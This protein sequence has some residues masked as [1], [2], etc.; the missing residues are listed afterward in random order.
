MGCG[1][2]FVLM[3]M[4]VPY[5]DPLLLQKAIEMY[6][7]RLACFIVEPIQGEAGVVVPD[8]GYLAAAAAL[9]KK[10]HTSFEPSHARAIMPVCS[11][12]FSSLVTRSKLA[13]REQGGCSPATMTACGRTLSYWARSSTRFI[14]RNVEAKLSVLLQAL[15]GGVY[16]VSAALCDWPIMKV[17]ALSPSICAVTHCCQCITPG[18]HGSTFG[19]NPVGCAAAIAALQVRRQASSCSMV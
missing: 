16:P 3:C 14:A 11:T 1:A 18:T 9:C 8:A 12:T 6:S 4:Q 2:M 19:G 15:S 7:D 13:L 5:N 10:V 17:S